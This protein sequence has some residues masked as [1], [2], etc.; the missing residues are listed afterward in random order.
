V[1]DAPAT[2]SGGKLSRIFKVA[3]GA[4]AT[5]SNLSLTGGIGLANIRLP[6]SHPDRGGAAVVDTG[7]A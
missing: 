2:I 7:G 5:L 1:G 6:Q 4:S 3:P